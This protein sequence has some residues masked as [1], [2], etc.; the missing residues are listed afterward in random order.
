M[1]SSRASRFCWRHQ[2][3]LRLDC[4]APMRPFSTR[5]TDN[6][7]L[8]QVVGGEDTDDPAADHDDVGTGRRVG[9]R[10][11]KAQWQWQDMAGALSSLQAGTL[12]H[13]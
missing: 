4:S 6:A 7:A 12:W 11:D 10:L 2:P 9:R 13:T 8:G 5:A 1:G 3:Q